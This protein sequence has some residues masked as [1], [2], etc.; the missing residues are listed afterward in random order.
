MTIELW[1]LFIA[2]LLHT[3]SKLPLVKAQAKMKGGYDNNNPREQQA[4][5]SGWGKR[6][7]A[8]HNNQIESFP[9]FA[10]GVLVAMVADVTSSAVGYLAVAYVI[11]RVL[12]IIF[13]V[14]DIS[15]WRSLVW[16]VGYFASLALLCSPTWG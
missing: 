15:K 6:A 8:A 2:G 11:S 3:L 10:T 7:H 14:K 12:Y 5:L 9:L 16:V 13:Y 4:S 1:C